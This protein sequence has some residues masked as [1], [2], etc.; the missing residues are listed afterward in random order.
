MTAFAD[1]YLVLLLLGVAIGF[2][3][4]I[5]GGLVDFRTARKRDGRGRGFGLPTLLVAGA[6]NTVVGLVVIVFS[7]L[8]TG[9][10]W[11]ALVVGFGVLVGFCLGFL[12]TAAAWILVFK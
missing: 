4:S 11:P 5:A 7:L 10:L 1:Q 3:G 9:T 8:F 12:L 6:I 2:L